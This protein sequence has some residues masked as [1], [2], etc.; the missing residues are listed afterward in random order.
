[1]AEVYRRFRDAYCLHHQGDALKSALLDVSVSAGHH[2]T[3]SQKT[4]NIKFV[5]LTIPVF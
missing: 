5:K 3:V 1:M 2:G 4:V